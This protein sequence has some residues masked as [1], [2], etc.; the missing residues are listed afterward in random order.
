M[1][2]CTYIGFDPG[3]TGGIAILTDTDAVVHDMPVSGKVSGKAGNEVNAHA[4]AEI[5][6]GALGEKTI[7]FVE[8]VSSMP[9]QGVASTYAFGEGA[10]VI[11]GVLGALGVQMEYVT[12]QRWKKAAGL[13]GTDKDQART[14]A[15]RSFPSLADSLKRKKDIGRADA[16]LIA[17]YGQEHA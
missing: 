12:P 6:R 3:L 16:L 7:A 10:G 14:L 8:K 11:R 17:K 5:V 1:T 13:I 4:L 15:I 2:S 9:G